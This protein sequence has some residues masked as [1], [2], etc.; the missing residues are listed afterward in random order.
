MRASARAMARARFSITVA[1]QDQ[2]EVWTMSNEPG[3]IG[4]AVVVIVVV[5]VGL[6]AVDT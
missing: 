3:A 5:V 1:V 6:V 4:A 2:G